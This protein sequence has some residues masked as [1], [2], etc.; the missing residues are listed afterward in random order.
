MNSLAFS[1]LQS[2][3]RG[4]L[5]LLAF[6]LEKREQVRE[7]FNMDINKKIAEAEAKE[8]ELK[9]LLETEKDKDK[10]IAIQQRIV[11]TQ[12]EKVSYVSKLQIERLSREWWLSG[13][14]QVFWGTATVGTTYV[15]G[16]MWG[17]PSVQARAAALTAGLLQVMY[18]VNSKR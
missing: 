15:V 1:S 8:V 6:D 11:A 10:W 9:A 17:L 13:A 5:L 4:P 18:G 2:G 3:Q 14:E 7:S 16:R 12:Q